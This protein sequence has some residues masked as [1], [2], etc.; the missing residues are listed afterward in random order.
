MEYNFLN[1]SFKEERIGI[2]FD[3]LC[4]K[5]GK[6]KQLYMCRKCDIKTCEVHKKNHRSVKC[7]L[8]EIIILCVSLKDNRDRVF[9]DQ[10]NILCKKCYNIK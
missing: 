1:L 7:G 10:G 5:D 4:E 8:C 3:C 9:N 2:C 6:L